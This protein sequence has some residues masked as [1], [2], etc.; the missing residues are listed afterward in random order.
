MEQDV[1][2]AV[3]IP[4]EQLSSDALEGLVQEFI[5]REGTDYGV[6][7][8]SLEAKQA[9]IVGQLKSGRIVVVFDPNEE[10]CSILRKEDLG[11]VKT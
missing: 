10:T 1:Q 4:F 7:E 8:V 2:P 9:Q 6:Q 5:L 11:R 3:I